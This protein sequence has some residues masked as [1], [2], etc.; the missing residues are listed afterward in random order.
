MSVLIPIILFLIGILSSIFGTLVGGAAFITIPVM[1]A[2]GI[3][4][5]FAISSN[6]F[7]NIGL[8]LGGFNKLNQKNLIHYKTGFILSAF[9]F[10]GS[11]IGSSLVIH[12][13]TVVIK[14]VFVIALSSI[15]ILTF[16]RSKIGLNDAQ[17]GGIRKIKLTI[18]GVLAFFLGSYSG[19]LGAGVGTFYTYGLVFIFGQSFLQSTATKKIPG[20]VQA[21]GAWLTFSL[22]G[23]MDYHVAMPLLLGMF[24]GSELGIYLGIRWGNR[25]IK[26][27][28]LTIVAILLIKFFF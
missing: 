26:K 12:T 6:A 4:L 9:A 7:G 17:S 3:P 19:F 27:L 18:G 28:F 22:A 25:F 23:K 8:N 14:S 15:L 24:I 20:L 5:I 16:L 11:V 1:T 21:I 2:L 13:P 10:I